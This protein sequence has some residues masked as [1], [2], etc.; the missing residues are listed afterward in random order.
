MDAEIR[1]S[2]R[3]LEDLPARLGT[4]HAWTDV[5]L[6]A[7]PDWDIH[8]VPTLVCCLEGVMRV[9]RPQGAQDLGPGDALVIGGGVWHR[10]APLRRGTRGWML[11]ILPAWS[12]FWIGSDDGRFFG[13]LPRAPVERLLLAAL[14]VE[15]ARRRDLLAAVVGLVLADAV[16]DAGF[17]TPAAQRMVAALW[18][19]L[20]Q[21]ITVDDLV[22]ASG[23]GRAQAYAVF[24]AAYGTSPK[25]A[26]AEG[27]LSLAA[28]LLDAGL[29]VSEAALRSGWPNVDTFSR[30]W[31]RRHGAPPS[32]R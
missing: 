9:Q 22:R 31:K 2:W 3:Q 7:K 25:A 17:R 28:S 15:P 32:R 4:V 13:R 16:P 27:R 30:A 1:Q 6:P 21:G 29:T 26:L 10:H 18:R 11:G 24:T 5:R 8:A 14:A 19:G 20:H 23:L 12:D